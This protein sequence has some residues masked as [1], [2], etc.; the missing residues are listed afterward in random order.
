MGK[1]SCKLITIKTE[2]SKINRL[3]DTTISNK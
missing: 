1:N 2:I 3:Y